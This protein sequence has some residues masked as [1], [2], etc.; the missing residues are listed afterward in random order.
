MQTLSHGRLFSEIDSYGFA[1]AGLRQ[2]LPSLS[3]LG[4]ALIPGS[5][6]QAEFIY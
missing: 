4:T 2:P 3:F 5:K 6:G 1:N